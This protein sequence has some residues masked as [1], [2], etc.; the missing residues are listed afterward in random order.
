MVRQTRTGLLARNAGC[1]DRCESA[2]AVEQWRHYYFQ[3]KRKI[4]LFRFMCFIK[5]H[6]TCTGRARKNKMLKIEIQLQILHCRF[7]EDIVIT[8]FRNTQ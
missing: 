5:S 8:Q 6:S 2:N 3:I 1:T 4:I 7:M